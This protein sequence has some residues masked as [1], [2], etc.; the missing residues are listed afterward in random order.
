M[1][2]GQAL[3]AEPIRSLPFSSIGATY[4]AVGTPIQN[5][6]RQF[7]LQNLTDATLMFSFD[8]VNDHFVLPANG[9]WLSDV[10]ANKVN[11]EG[12]FLIINTKLFVKRVGT[13]SS[14]TVYFSVFNGMR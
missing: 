7:F 13:P 12:F 1:A 2:E 3:K 6:T 10:T 9:F 11:E 4:V 8:G 5:T 14:G